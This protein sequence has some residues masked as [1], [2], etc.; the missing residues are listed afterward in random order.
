[1]YCD[2]ENGP[3]VFYLGF[4][5]PKRSEKD[6]RGPPDSEE[7]GTLLPLRPEPPGYRVALDSFVKG[8]H[9]FEKLWVFFVKE[10]DNYWHVLLEAL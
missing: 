10:L 5:E 6:H 1:M 9:R 7:E 4:A 8:D 2:L 3:V